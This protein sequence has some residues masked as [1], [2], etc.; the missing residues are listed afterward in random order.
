MR[1]DSGVPGPPPH[2][3]LLRCAV[4]LFLSLWL[5]WASSRQGCDPGPQCAPPH[6][7]LSS[8]TFDLGLGPTPAPTLRRQQA[9]CLPTSTRGS[10]RHRVQ[11]LWSQITSFLWPVLSLQGWR[12]VLLTGP[13]RGPQEWFLAHGGC[14]FPWS[15][16]RP[17]LGGSPQSSTNPALFWGPWVPSGLR[18]D[19][20]KLLP[21]RRPSESC[22]VSHLDRAAQDRSP[23]RCPPTARR[24]Q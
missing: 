20:R 22:P 11:S 23:L 7:L 17:D 19:G 13:R 4:E 12:P 2:P 18:R 6:L 3:L 14:R 1:T 24:G 8:V 5:P 10:R 16:S 21:R 15:I 9:S